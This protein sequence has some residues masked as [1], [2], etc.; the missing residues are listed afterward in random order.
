MSCGRSEGKS[1]IG[2]INETM[3]CAAR[4]ALETYLREKQYFVIPR[5]DRVYKHMYSHRYSRSFVFAFH[6][7]PPCIEVT[8][9]RHDS[10]NNRRVVSLHLLTILLGPLLY[11]LLLVHTSPSTT[12]PLCSENSVRHICNALVLHSP[13]HPMSHPTRHL[14][15]Q[16]SSTTSAPTQLNSRRKGRT[17]TLANLPP[18]PRTL[19]PV[20]SS[21]CH[22][23]CVTSVS[24]P[25]MTFQ[26]P[27]SS[28]ICI[29]CVYAGLYAISNRTPACRSPVSLSLADLLARKSLF[30]VVARE[31][32]TGRF[33]GIVAMATFGMG[34][35]RER[36]EGSVAETS[37]SW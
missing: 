4:W 10:R 18:T 2:R 3:L 23:P 9:E 26:P 34:E 17:L 13:P 12:A 11:E 33:A 15:R 25:P 19:T 36:L 16:H 29:T 8:I 22:I 35:K 21:N 30:R 1:G 7:S 31:G 5:F 32:S 28:A 27:T 6:G 24:R 20:H 37:L 14:P